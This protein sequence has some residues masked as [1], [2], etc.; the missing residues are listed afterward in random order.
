M[1]YLG[2][3]VGPS[4]LNIGSGMLVGT[5]INASML[6][7]TI[8]S[9]VIAPKLMIAHGWGPTDTRP[10]VLRWVMWPATGMLIAGG[11]TALVVK[12]RL[13]VKTFARFNTKT[14]ASG[15]FPIRWVAIGA[16]ICTVALALVQYFSLGLPIWMTLIAVLLSV[17]LMLVGLRVLGETNWGPISALSNMM[18]GVFAVVAPHHVSA[19]MASSGTTGN[20]AAQ[21]EGLMQDFKVAEL[22]GSTPKYM[23][24]AEL[25]AVPIGAAATAIMYPL[26]KHTYGVGD[27][28]GP[29]ALASPVSTKW[30]GFA[31]LLSKGISALPSSALWALLIFAGIGVV[32]TLLETKIKWLPSPTGIGIG[33]LIPGN[34]VVTMFLGGLVE[35][36]W[37]RTRPKSA[38]QI[39]TPLAS[40]FIAGEAIVAVIV[41]LLILAGVWPKP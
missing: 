15:E 22:I 40:G 2:M 11:L 3:G 17:P 16:A 27:S 7:G 36:V 38:E 30:A 28:G 12:W 34:A 21:S 25:I 26:L 14:V 33:M 5:R 6:L 41:P 13:L 24:Y 9:W 39:V 4:L 29:H 8:L 31:E 1:A 37:R 32:L 35:M 18:Q 20:I 23:T 19:N 10:H